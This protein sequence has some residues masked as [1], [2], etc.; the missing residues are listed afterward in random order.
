MRILFALG[1]I[2]KHESLMLCWFFK[3]IIDADTVLNVCSRLHTNEYLTTR[4][5]NFGFPNIPFI[6]VFNIIN[7]CWYVC[8]SRTISTIDH[9]KF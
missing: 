6:C 9:W 4:I 1:Q 7:L 3:I 2:F 8:V 5:L